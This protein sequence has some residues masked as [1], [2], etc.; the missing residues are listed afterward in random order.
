MQ[1]ERL[2]R[3]F[4]LSEFYSPRDPDRSTR[5]DPRLV[6]G[7]QAFRDFINQEGRE[8]RIIITSGVR[9]PAYNAQI[10]GAPRSQHV[11][12]RAADIAVVETLA[13]G[14]YRHWTSEEIIEA[15][16]RFGQFTGRGLYPGQYF[17]HVD[18]R[19]GLTG[20]VTRWVE[21]IEDGKKT[22]PAVA[23]FGPWLKEGDDV[24]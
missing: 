4:R 15:V 19:R 2:S 24:A 5:P 14:T 18:V 11:L 23:D 9:S 3:N 16:E 13:R 1:D 8:K 17:A 7:L 21:Q 22:W 6:A 12:G 10:G 20:E